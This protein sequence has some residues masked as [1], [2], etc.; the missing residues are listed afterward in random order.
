MN[1]SRSIDQILWQHISSLPYFRGML[2]AVE[3]SFYQDLEFPSPSL[4]L[5]CGDGH[6]AATAIG[7]GMDVGL[8]PWAA[9]LK[10][11]VGR[12]YYK[13][14]VQ[15]EGSCLPF[16]GEFFSS[17][18]SNSVLEHIPDI[19]SVLADL[20]RVLKPG[21][22][23]VFSVPNERFPLELW[24]SKF[25]GAIGAP[26]LGRK[27][28]QSFNR[29]ISRHF[30]TDSIDVWTARLRRAGL[31]VERCWNYF[32]PE[33]LHI[34]EWGHVFGLPSLFWR[35]LTGKWILVP[36]KSN[37]MIPFR[38]AWPSM[39]NPLSDRG[40]CTFYIARKRDLQD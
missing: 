4:D 23:F 29:R 17:A 31:S 24:G 14:T 6:F 40:V 34:L 26:S 7:Q 37:L 5:G 19:D 3:D 38:L 22:T 12:T 39:Q 10:E 36:A 18:I 21:A 2:R 1:P 35:K 30:H 8:D 28:G 27:Y 25:L 32:P 20:S 33:A 16:P 11:A 9:P 15:S 13:L